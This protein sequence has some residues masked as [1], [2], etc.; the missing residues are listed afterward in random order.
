MGAGLEGE[1]LRYCLLPW[2]DT[3]TKT[4]LYS[5]RGLDRDHH[6]GPRTAEHSQLETEPHGRETQ[7]GRSHLRPQ[8]TPS[9]I[10]SNKAT[11]SSPS[12]AVPPTG[13]KYSNIRAYWGGSRSQ[14]HSEH[15]RQVLHV[16]QAHY[17]WATS[18]ATT[19]LSS[20]PCTHQP[21]QLLRTNP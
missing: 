16:R 14:H 19:V 18:D 20:E 10:F 4:T 15:P 7:N 6:G 11:P 13:Y 2:W 1:G 5:I 9:D 17:H 3:V 8:S 21:F 12:Q